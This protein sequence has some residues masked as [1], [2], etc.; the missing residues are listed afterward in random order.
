[1]RATLDAHENQHRQIAERERVRTQG[2]FR[3][4]DFTVNGADRAAARAAVAAEMQS[5]QAQWAADGQAAQDA[6][7]PFRGAVLACPAPTNP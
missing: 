7:D 1:M 6:I 3:A 4:L 2:E 5:R